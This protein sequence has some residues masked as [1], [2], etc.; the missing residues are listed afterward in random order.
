M[1]EN[2]RIVLARRL[3][4]A[5]MQDDFRLERSPIPVPGDGELLLETLYLSL[6]PYMRGRMSDEASYAPPVGLGEVIVGRAISRILASNNPAFQPD[7]IV[8]AASGWQSHAVSDGVGLRALD[9]DAFAPTLA[10]GVV[11][12]SGFAAWVGLN[13]I[14]RVAAG[15]TVVVAA[16]TGP[17]GA[18]VVQLA[19]AAGARVIAIAGAPDEA[20]YACR[21]SGPRPGGFR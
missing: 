9:P 20:A 14:A 3:T 2:H 17:V 5:P 11:G 10:L 12:N 15:D 4:G 18:T 13:E 21:I 16:A 19:K 7:R 8:L 6:D 1:T